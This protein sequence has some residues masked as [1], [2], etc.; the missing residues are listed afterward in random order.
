VCSTLAQLRQALAGYAA[1]FDAAL[2]APADL[3]GAISDAGAIEKMASTIS[4][5]LSAHLARGAGQGP[6]GSSAERQAALVLARASG[7]SVSEARRLL[8]AA[9]VMVEEPS[10]GAAARAGELSRDQALIVS[11][12]VAANPKAANDLLDAARRLPISELAA[13]AARARA[14]AEDLGEARRRTHANRY[15]RSWSDAAGAWHL[16]ALGLPEHGAAVMAALGPLAEA[17]FESARKQSRRERPEAYNFDALVALANGAER[18]CRPG[19]E[20]MVRIDHDALLRG[21]VAEGETSEIAGFGPV[22]PSVVHQLIETADP[23][24]KA[25]VTKGKDIVGVAHLG[26]RPNA[27]QKSALEW[28]YPTCAA[29]GCPTRASFLQTDHRT[30]WAKTHFTLY[31]LL[32]RLCPADHRL[33]THHGWALVAGKGK[34]SFV[35]PDDPRHPRHAVTPN[36]ETTPNREAPPP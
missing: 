20:V 14:E 36:T 12:A 4:T 19:Y 8:D 15:L 6:S 27:Y 33:K 29:E 13:E 1:N 25:I 17:A 11:S 22:P 31:D 30:D 7:T 28:L 23:F 9:K 10:L 2:V 24:L 32:D 21:A 18:S 5:L 16:S 35:P 26:R 34:R 3:G